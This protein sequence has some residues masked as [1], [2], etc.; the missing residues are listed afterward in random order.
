[1]L[2]HQKHSNTFILEI[3]MCC[4]RIS[5][6]IDTRFQGMAKGVG[7]AKI[8]G[9]VHYTEVKIG[10]HYTACS[11]TVLDSDDMEFLLGLDM[12]KKHQVL[13]PAVCEYLGLCFF[14]RCALTCSRTV[15]ESAKTK[16]RSLGLRYDHST[17]DGT[18]TALR[19]QPLVQELPSWASTMSEG[20]AAAAQADEEKAPD[21]AESSPSQPSLPLPNPPPHSV[22]TC[23]TSL[24]S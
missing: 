10:Q 24:S 8:L 23:T 17:V 12:L 13:L 20:A 1:M 22:N 15:C 7:S 4:F 2:F 19:H 5:H 3:S 9:K 16:Y 6:L 11:I 14:C 18:A 21:V